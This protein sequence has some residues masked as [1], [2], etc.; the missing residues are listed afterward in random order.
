M[1]TPC[2]IYDLGLLGQTLSAASMAAS[3]SGYFIHYAIKANHN[4]Q[5]LE[6]IR[7]GGFGADCVSG[8]ELDAALKAGFSADSVVFAGVGKTDE[9]IQQALRMEICSINCESLEEL[10]VIADLA[11]SMGKKARVALRV[12]PDV[13]AAT[14]PYITTGM[15][16]NKFGIHAGLL[17]EALRMCH[18]NPFLQLMG[19]HFHIGSQITTPEPYIALC[20]R[21]SLL[22]KELELDRSGASML[23]LGGGLGIDYSDPSHN[24]VPDFEA[25]FNI[26]RRE[27]K[28]PSSVGVHFELG[29]SLVGQS[30]SIVSKV[31]YV[32]TGGHRKMIVLDAGMTELLRPALYKARHHIEHTMAHCEEPLE[33]YDVVG[34]SCE[35]SDVF[36]RG[37]RLPQTKRGDLLVIRSCGAYGQSMSLRYNMRPEAPDYYQRPDSDNDAKKPAGFFEPIEWDCV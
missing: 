28:I 18:S 35:S 31:L 25:F 9:E 30:G 14:H 21:V 19:L 4:P 17:S 15:E 32:K 27:L 2:F 10:Q 23:N 3:R 7:A 34:P 6:P 33:T 26:F 1:K 12:N 24:P 11:A 8:Q 13:D 29:R 16:D 37:I 20:H 36:A 5:I 22:W